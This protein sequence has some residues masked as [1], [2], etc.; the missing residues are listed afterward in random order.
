MDGCGEDE[1]RVLVFSSLL[2]LHQTNFS[3]FP[4]FGCTNVHNFGVPKKKLSEL[5]VLL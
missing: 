4:E 2:G 5:A 1:A 3:P